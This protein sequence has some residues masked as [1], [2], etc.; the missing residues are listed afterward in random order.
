MAGVSRDSPQAVV[1]NRGRF[2]VYDEN[3]PKEFETRNNPLILIHNGTVIGVVRVDIHDSV[4]VVSSGRRARGFA[5]SGS[6]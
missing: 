3:H 4:A 1:E 6:W 5:E 2:G